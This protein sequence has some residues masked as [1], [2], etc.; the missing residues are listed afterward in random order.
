MLFPPH[1]QGMLRGYL[2]LNEGR[3]SQFTMIVVIGEP[4]FF[5][6]VEGGLQGELTFKLKR[7][8]GKYPISGIVVGS[9][10]DVGFLPLAHVTGS[11][12]TS[13]DKD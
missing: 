9:T 2:E 5:T 8:L 6:I 10:C 3:L 11:S 12:S 7:L 4:D 13:P 1:V